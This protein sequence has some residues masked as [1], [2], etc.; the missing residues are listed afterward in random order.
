MARIF[1]VF[2]LLSGLSLNAQPVLKGGLESFVANNKVYPL[3]SLQNCIDGSVTIGFKLNKNGEVYYSEI[4]KGVGTDLDDEALRLIRTSS[5]RW[6][7]P[8]DHDS[9]VVIIAPINFKLSGYDCANKSKEEILE[10]I[11]NYKNNRGL[12]DA[13]L[14]FY[15]K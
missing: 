6:T 12:T 14:N 5:G 2:F 15:R 3:Y 11:R 8:Q 13:V 4:R 10:A 1:L 9:T 7:V